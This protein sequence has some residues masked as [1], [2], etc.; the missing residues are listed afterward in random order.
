MVFLEFGLGAILGSL[1]K[2]LADRSLTN[3]TFLG[4]SKCPKCHHQLNYY[5]LFPIV[6]L[7]LLKGK[8]RYCSKSVGW[9]YLWVEIVMGILVAYLFQSSVVSSQLSATIILDLGYKIFFITT[10]VILFLT[11]LRKMLIPDRITYPAI[12]VSLVYTVLIGLWQAIL[13]GILIAGFFMLL[14]IITRGKG[15]GGG[16]VKLG[17]L[18]GLALGF[19]NSMLALVLAFL[20]GAILA[21]LLIVLGKKRFGQTL[22]FGPFL[23]LGALTALFW[24]K[25][26]I[27]WYLQF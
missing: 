12:L 17:A 4:R 2:A 16:D 27:S 1:A 15:M 13:M 10:L 26:I 9:E 21:L 14:I 22:P 25:E 20:S 8:C 7:L 23:V 3:Q 11:D 6:S 24:G 18:M 19:P 5:D